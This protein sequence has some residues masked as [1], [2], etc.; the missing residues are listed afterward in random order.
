MNF[1][2]TKFIVTGEI[3]LRQ[4]VTIIITASQWFAVM[5]LPDDQWQVEVKEE[6]ANRFNIA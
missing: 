4:L 6:N 3:N 2:T 1:K 5:P